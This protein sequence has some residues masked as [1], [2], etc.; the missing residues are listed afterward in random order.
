MSVPAPDASVARGFSRWSLFHW[1]ALLVATPLLLL[2]VAAATNAQREFAAAERAALAQASSLARQAA[3]RLDEHYDELDQFLTAVAE[4][5]RETLLRGAD[6]DPPLTRM[7]H[8][9]AQHVTGLSILSLDGRMLASTTAAPEMRAK[10]NVADRAYFKGAISSGRLVVGEPVYSRTTELWVSISARPVFDDAGRAIGV[11]STSA[12]LDRIQTILVPAGLPPGTLMTVFNGRG[13]GI[14]SSAEPRAAPGRDF[15]SLETVRRVLRDRELNAKAQASDGQLR[16]LSYAAGKQLPWTVEVGLS[17]EHALAPARRQLYQRLSLLAVALILGLAAAAWLARRIGQPIRDLARDADELGKGDL[18]RRTQVRGYH[19]VNR[20]SRAL[21][22]MADSL[23]IRQRELHE[24]EERL[25]ATLDCSPNVAVQ[26]YDRDGRVRFW[27]KAST[28]VLGWPEEEVKG[29]TL[30]EI[31]LYTPAQ[32]REFIAALRSVDHEGPRSK[33]AESVI[34]RKDGTQGVIVSTL[35]AIP[36]P[37]GEPL[38]AC[39]DVD[40]TER[41]AL[42]EQRQAALTALRENEAK[43]RALTELSSDWYWEQDADFRFT[44]VGS[45]DPNWARPMIGKTRWELDGNPLKGTWAEHQAL[46]TRHETFRNVEFRYT[47]AHGATA[48]LAVSGE[49]VY[50][51]TGRFAGY[52]GTA[53]DITVKMRLENELAERMELFRVTLETVPVAIG[54]V[55]TQ[56]NIA[57]LANRAA[58]ELLRIEPGRRNWSVLDYWETRGDARELK[59]RLERDGTVRDMEIPVRVA[60]RDNVWAQLS[61]QPARYLGE[62]VTVA[63]LN[64]ITAR[65]ALEAQQKVLE[66]QRESLLVNLRVANERLQLL[67]RQVLDAQEAERRQIAHELHDEIGQNLSAL[68]L[69]AG[70]LRTHLAP[71]LQVQVD[72][73]VDLLDRAIGQV[74]DLSRLL[75]PVQLDHMGLAAALRALLDTQARAAGWSVDF[76]ADADLPRLDT[77]QETVAYRVAQEALTNA[78]RHADAAHVSLE[79]KLAAGQL[80]LTLSDD[81]RGFDVEAA[82]QRVMQGRSMGLLGME[83]RVQ[84]AG[85]TFCIDS[86][87]TQGTRIMVALPTSAEAVQ[88]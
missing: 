88:T 7:I 66:L 24:S 10:V 82:R 76:A 65:K 52:R 5:A 16:F 19:E 9:T 63:T 68:K 34:R 21:N 22:N 47:G 8:A 45:D 17:V 4:V 56:D 80:R 1:L 50:D 61:A 87:P 14:A 49:P 74:R 2:V 55:R 36:S 62:A 12:R 40:I 44:S 41:K 15:S 86:A 3:A 42:E 72:E 85:G 75:R 31:G 77:R 39:M 18:A 20:L 71:A 6:G 78:A 23:G 48:Y 58:H 30:G 64:D 79:V 46:L 26:W 13:I 83:E 33:P 53:S 35:F 54:V 67:S 73:W 57:L 32:S 29:R 59:R 60:G 69:F 84:L 51:T 11:V 25:R 27:N 81:G 28:A 37:S 43:F 38:Y 70:H